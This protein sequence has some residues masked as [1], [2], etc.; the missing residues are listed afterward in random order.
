MCAHC[1][2]SSQHALFKTHIGFLARQDGRLS[3]LT[4]AMSHTAPKGA[5]H[6]QTML[7]SSAV[8][9]MVVAEAEYALY[10]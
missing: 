9:L 3:S 7:A 6:L 4:A 1:L 8:G 10:Q 5:Q 2:I